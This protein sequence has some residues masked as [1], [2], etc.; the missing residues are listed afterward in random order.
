M[1]SLPPL[2][3]PAAKATLREWFMYQA[4]GPKKPV[5]SNAAT[6]VWS[7]THEITSLSIGTSGARAAVPN[8]PPFLRTDAVRELSAWAAPTPDQVALR[9]AYLDATR[10]NL[11]S[12]LEGA[13]LNVLHAAQS[14]AVERVIASKLRA[15]DTGERE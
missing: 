3:A 7:S 14:A 10:Q 11:T 12:V 15:F 6:Y 4:S 8:Q 9:G 13:R 5:R 2:L 1:L